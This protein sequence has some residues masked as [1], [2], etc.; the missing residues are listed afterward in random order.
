MPSLFLM[1]VLRQHSL[2]I[3]D[4]ESGSRIGSSLAVIPW[5]PPSN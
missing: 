5:L 1:E 4:V 2:G 3:A